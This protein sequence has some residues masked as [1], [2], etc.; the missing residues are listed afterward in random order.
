MTI[1]KVAHLNVADTLIDETLDFDKAVGVALDFAKNDEHVRYQYNNRCILSFYIDKQLKTI[2]GEPFGVHTTFKNKRVKNILI[3]FFLL[4]GMAVKAQT[5]LTIAGKTY[6]NSDDTWLGVNIPRTQPT[7]FVFKNNS[8]TSLNRFGYML[9]AGDEGANS[10]NN[11]L[12][13]ALITGNKFKWTGTD[14]SCI[15]H[16]LFTG[17]N[18]D[19]VVKYNY[20]DYVP[21]GIIRKSTT[22]MKNA[23]GG[24]AYNIVKSGAVAVVVKGISNVNI[25]NNTFYSDRTTT[26]TWRPLVHIYTN[27]DAGRYSVAHGTKIYNN[28]FYT[29]YQ[30]FSV[31]VD[32]TESLTGFKCDYNVYWCETGAPRFY[33]NGSIKSFAEWQALGFDTHSVVVNPNFEDLINFVPA[34]RLDFGTGLGAE[35]ANGLSPDA[36]WGPTNP[37]SSAQNG[38]WQVGAVIRSGVNDNLTELPMYINSEVEHATPFWLEMTYNLIDANIIPPLSA[39]NV[40]VNSVSRN[41][42]GVDISGT[43]VLLTLGTPVVYGDVIMVAYSKPDVNPLQTSG[44]EAQDLSMQQVTNKVRN[45][46]DSDN[47]K[48]SVYPNPA[49]EFINISNLESSVDLYILRIF[50]LTGRLYLE[51]RFNPDYNSNIPVNLNSGIYFIQV[52]LGSASKFVQRLVIIE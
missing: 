14:T 4:M 47:A 16:G 21:M 39:F 13:R 30:T 18:I 26:Q 2:F 34:S 19:V 27:T 49:R 40:N 9:Q 33:V 11:N 44:G 41:I 52:L 8:I 28:I 42:T 24:I 25:Y 36:V 23:E 15:T 20:L 38:I 45:I 29:K 32:D 43:K 50:D 6:T 17:H 7:T 5:V 51:T 1:F 37:K 35:W 10:T 12:D 22:N 3:I 46:S 31:S 48:I